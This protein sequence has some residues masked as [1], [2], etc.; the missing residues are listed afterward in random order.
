MHLLKL[1]QMKFVKTYFRKYFSAIHSHDLTPTIGLEIHVRLTTS[2]KLF[3]ESKNEFSKIPNSY[4]DFFDLSL[5]GTQPGSIRS[6]LALSCK[7]PKKLSFDR[8]HYFYPDQPAGY[9]ITQY[10][11]PLAK[12]GTIKLYKLEKNQLKP[13]T[14]KIKQIHLEQDTGRILYVSNPS[15]LLIDFNRMGSPLIEIITEPCISSGKEAGEA[16]KKIQSILRNAD[17]S[18]VII[19]EGG[20]RCDVNVSVGNHPKCEIKNLANYEIK[21]QI[22]IINLGKKIEKQT[23]GYDTEKNITIK[24]RKKKDPI[25]YRYIPD[26]DLPEIILSKKLLKECKNSITEPKNTDFQKYSSYPYK[27]LPKTIKTLIEKRAFDYFEKILEKLGN[28]FNYS[29]IVGDWIVNKLL[30]Q[31]NSRK[32]PFEKNPVSPDQLAFIIKAIE[33]NYITNTSAKFILQ[34]IIDGNKQEIYD[35]I[36]SCNYERTSDP[37]LMLEICRKILNKHKKQVDQYKLGQN[38]VIKWILGRVMKETQGKFPAIELEQL[39]KKMIHENNI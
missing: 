18:D 11:H 1:F 16:L 7:F 38:K 29:E 10:Y 6:A 13:V 12:D 5:P 34:N 20:L 27:L 39:L 4:I 9:Q 17:I 23:L 25:Y 32:I 28:P 8:K 35:I 33:S 2:T 21:R 3:S 15:R 22:S 37:Y 24:L 30:G 19:E 36:K 26:P 14:I 31:L